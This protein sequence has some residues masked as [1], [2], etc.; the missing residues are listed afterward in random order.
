MP[1]RK[2]ASR[3]HRSSSKNSIKA[4]MAKANAARIAK[5][6]AEKLKQQLS[7]SNS[8]SIPT[9]IPGETNATVELQKHASSYSEE[10][11]GLFTDEGRMER[12]EE[13][14]EGKE[15]QTQEDEETP[16]PGMIIHLMKL[17][18]LFEGTLCS[19]CGKGPITLRRDTTNSKTN[20]IF[21]GLFTQCSHCQEIIG[22]ANTYKVQ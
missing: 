7:A 22:R 2:F 5:R 18:G 17:N 10:K 20:S 14:N 13:Q 9:A 16:I 15:K 8:N 4:R 3:Q 11:C 21:V 1:G 19:F 6:A 12:H